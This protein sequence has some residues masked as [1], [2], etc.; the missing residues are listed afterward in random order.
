MSAAGT[1][2]VAAAESDSLGLGWTG[3]VMQILQVVT[4]LIVVNVM[5]LLG[6]LLGLGLLGLM[7]AAVAASAVLRRGELLSGAAEDGIVRTFWGRYRAEFVRANLAG[8]PL[9]ASAAL[10]AADAVVLPQLR[11]PASAVLL[12]LTGILIAGTAIIGVVTIVLL[13]RYADRPTAVLRFAL[14]MPLTSPAMTAGVFVVLLAWAALASTV[15]LLLPL[16]GAAVP[17]AVAVR[18]IDRRL[19]RI[20]D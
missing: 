9:A 7:P 11:G 13:S 18:L 14:L 20:A 5:F 2:R 19:D 6:T 8:L 15:P 10:L 16:V 1:A 12:A 17:L 4:A 3:R